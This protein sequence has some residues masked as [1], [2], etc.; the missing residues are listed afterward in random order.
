MGQIFKI[1]Q[2]DACLSRIERHKFCGSDKL[3]AGR[4]IH[5]GLTGDP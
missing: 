5:S 3:D 1:C 4:E 2:A